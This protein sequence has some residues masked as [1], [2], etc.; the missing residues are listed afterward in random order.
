MGRATPFRCSAAPTAGVRNP[1]HG[2]NRTDFHGA[3][4]A[5]GQRSRPCAPQ[6]EFFTNAADPGKSVSVAT[7]EKPRPVRR[8]T[9]SKQQSS[10]SAQ[11]GLPRGMWEAIVCRAE[12]WPVL[13]IGRNAQQ[14]PARARNDDGHNI[15]WAEAKND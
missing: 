4:R 3:D 2:E 13:A 1:H 14:R 8:R 15:K 6:I 11:E 5:E 7:L 10:C 12:A 9:Q